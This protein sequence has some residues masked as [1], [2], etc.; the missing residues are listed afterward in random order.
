MQALYIHEKSGN[1]I[2]AAIR[3]K[4]SEETA[5]QRAVPVIDDTLGAELFIALPCEANVTSVGGTATAGNC[6]SVR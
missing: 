6:R 5:Q 1:Q 2:V 3:A 4:L